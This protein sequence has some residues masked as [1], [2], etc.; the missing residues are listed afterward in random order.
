[1]HRRYD[2]YTETNMSTKIGFNGKGVI[3]LK[4]YDSLTPRFQNNATFLHIDWLDLNTVDLTD[5]DYFNTAIRS[6]SDEEFMSRVDSLSLSYQQ[7]NFSTTYW[8]PCFGTD[9][10]PRDGRGRI[11]AA[12]QNGERWIPKAVYEYSDDSLRNTITNG[13]IA[14]DHDPAQRPNM[15][16]F[17]EAGVQLISNGELKNFKSDITHWLYKEAKVE[18]FIKKD[19][20]HITKIINAIEKRGENGGNPIIKAIGSE[21]CHAWIEKNLKLKNRKDYILSAVDNVTYIN[22]TWCEGILPMIL[23]SQ[24]PINIILYTSSKDE[25]TARN[26]VNNFVKAI[27]K[28]YESS[29]KMINESIVGISLNIPAKKDRPY[30]FIGAIPQIVGKHYQLGG[31]DVKTLISIEDY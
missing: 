3:D 8:P 1:M 24:T 18:N 20:G 13:I 11:T 14:N 10:K 21:K 25:Q 12:K 30:K 29:F 28:H 9:G 7:K 23:K 22:R 17:I 6:E 27:H 16:D 19:G 31:P 2:V 4:D 15:E 5:E 26:N